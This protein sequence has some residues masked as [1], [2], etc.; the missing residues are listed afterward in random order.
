M[1]TFR[2]S[3]ASAQWCVAA[4]EGI[5]VGSSSSIPAGLFIQTLFDSLLKSNAPDPRFVPRII[6]GSQFLDEANG[7]RED[8]NLALALELAPPRATHL[9]SSQQSTSSQPQ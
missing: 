6:D 4:L 1:P 9:G 7:I 2:G 3:L 5:V 8:G